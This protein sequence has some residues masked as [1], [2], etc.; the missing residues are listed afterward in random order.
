[1]WKMKFYFYIVNLFCDSVSFWFSEHV[2]TL[3]QTF[4]KY[5]SLKKKK[6]CNNNSISNISGS[7]WCVVLNRIWDCWWCVFLRCKTW[8]CV[9]TST[10]IHYNIHTF[11][12]RLEK[13]QWTWW[14]QKRDKNK[15]VIVFLYDYL[16]VSI[17]WWMNMGYKRRLNNPF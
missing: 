15:C 12:N 14:M 3:H 17:F 6:N 16:Y 10:H 9:Y 5:R 2:G 8:L 4:E 1:M 11:I 7:I 13:R